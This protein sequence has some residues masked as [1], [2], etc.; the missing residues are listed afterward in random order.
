MFFSKSDFF[1]QSG[2]VLICKQKYVHNL[3]EAKG[4]SLAKIELYKEAYVYFSNN[5]NDF[6]GA[7]FVKDLNDIIGLDL[8][9]M[10][11]DYNYLVNN[12]ASNFK[13]KWKADWLYAKEQERKGKGSY[14]AFSRFIGLTIIGLFFVPYARIKRGKMTGSQLSKFDNTYKTLTK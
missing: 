7:T 8:D 5:P 6:D 11:H 12:V 3:L 14:S 2:H 10:L 13:T 4:Y 9:A 1:K